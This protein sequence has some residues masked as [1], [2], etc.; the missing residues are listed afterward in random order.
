MSKIGVGVGEDFLV[1]DAPQNPARD[2]G[3]NPRARFGH[4]PKG[5]GRAHRGH[6]PFAVP[7]ALIAILLI[8]A[9]AGLTVIA[10]K[11]RS[12]NWVWNTARSMRSCRKATS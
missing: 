9:L 4:P 7:P 5:D 11:P 10:M 8:A 12:A 2:G 6:Y 1:N 3:C